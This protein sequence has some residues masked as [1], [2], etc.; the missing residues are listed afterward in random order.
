MLRSS[1]Q[2][3]SRGLVQG[4]V[5]SSPSRSQHVNSAIRRR[6]M[7]TG[8][9]AKSGG[10]G[11]GAGT[12]VLGLGVAGVGGTVAYAGMD[13]EFRK[14]VEDV[15]PGTSGV[16]SMIH[17]DPEPEKPEKPVPSKKKPPPVTTTPPSKMRSLPVTV[18][19]SQLT[20]ADTGSSKDSLGA[21]PTLAP[22]LEKPSFMKEEAKEEKKKPVDPPKVEEEEPKKEEEQVKKVVEVPKK[23]EVKKVENEPKK[24]EK[25]KKK[26]PPA[27][28]AKEEEEV[29]EEKEAILAGKD[30]HRKVSLVREELEQEMRV[31][32]KRQSEAHADHIQDSMN[33]Q[34]QELT[35]QHSRDL[36]EATEKAAIKH[37]EELGGIIGHLQGLQIA[38]ESRSN[39]ELASLEA[40]ELWLACTALQSAVAETDGKEIRNLNKEITAIKKV[41]QNHGKDP[42][43]KSILDSIPDLAF[44]RG[45]YTEGSIRERFLKVEEVAKQ[46]AMIG[47]EGGSLLRYFLSYLQSKVIMDTATTEIPSKHAPTDIDKLNTFDLVWLARGSL[48]RGD[49]DQAVRYMSLLQGEPK[50]VSG[51]WLKEARLLLETKQASKAL[52]AHAAA[53]GVEA[54]PQRRKH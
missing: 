49:L 16:F 2:S 39:M 38:L 51:D 1:T 3:L 48:D 6:G 29:E 5:R 19:D 11:L 7:A 46:T 25:I 15:V 30:L 43:V 21:A 22:P 4:S 33:V 53:V 32:L 10:G 52:T 50:N 18:T 34:K 44:R 14:L 12:A 45:V 13:N 24:E 37:R 54:L 42:F 17:G 27:A 8:P 28:A 26:M 9:G 47:P 35:R 23:E 31:Q 41:L 36:D 40:Q 20:A